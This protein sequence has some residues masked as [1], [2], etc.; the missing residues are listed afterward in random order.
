M[1]VKS[2]SSYY[3]EIF[4]WSFPP[5]CSEYSS[6]NVMTHCNNPV[7]VWIMRQQQ[8]SFYRK[9][10]CNQLCFMCMQWQFIGYQGKFL[11]IPP[12]KHE[13]KIILIPLALVIL[14]KTLRNVSDSYKH[15]CTWQIL[16]DNKCM[17][18]KGTSKIFFWTI[19]QQLLRLY[20]ALIKS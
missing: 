14:G 18:H 3:S 10:L 5:E 12:P 1:V 17:M 20:C 4:L 2:T 11:H 6:R 8:H 7:L 13:T 19:T 15:E 9:V 16:K